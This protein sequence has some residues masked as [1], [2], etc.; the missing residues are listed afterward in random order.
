MK[1]LAAFD[2]FKDAMPASMACEAALSGALEALGEPL[3]LSHAPL[4]DGGEGF[5]PILTEAARGYMEHH[6]VS[7]PLG[8][9]VDSPLG[10]VNLEQIPENARKLL[11]SIKGKL[12]IIEM[13]SVAGLEQ[14]PNAQRHPK[15]CTTRG[16]GE[17]IRIAV[18]EEADA[19]LLG[20]GGSA[21]SDLGL[22]A[23]EALGL[24]FCPSGQVTPAQWPVIEQIAGSIELT[25]P[26]IY[27]ACDV[28]NPLLGTRG[29][30]AVYGPQKGL[31]PDEIK[32]FDSASE[33]IAK[34]LC[35]FFKQPEC[36]LR[37]SGS[38]AAG[39]IGFGLNV[40]FG[41]NYVAGFELVTAWLDLSRK[42]KEADLVLT[43]EGKF[44]NS[45]L[46]GKGPFALLAAAYSCDTSAILL[47]GLADEG[48]TQTVYDR[49][50][51]TAVYSI[52]PEGTPLAK[53][54]K[55]AP[56]FL[57]QKVSEVL[58]TLYTHDG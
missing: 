37:A 18:A 34:Q 17:L 15:H 58:H 42:I 50:P 16:V 35:E 51:G 45:S 44:D 28:N 48:A 53:A 40:A 49:F 36:T 56:D 31:K 54:L 47:A 8:E 22:G 57:K 5:C 3:T 11:G 12:A 30:A 38:G 2:K 39:G 27:I 6:K 19:I 46:A 20:I 21:T 10:W 23:L 43:G 33:R 25:V 9:Q 4:T 41:S 14:V 52:T 29:A 24:Q 32:A 1:I 7:G 26:P 13:A 55:L